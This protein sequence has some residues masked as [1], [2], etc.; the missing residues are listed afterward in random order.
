[1]SLAPATVQVLVRQEQF[2]KPLLLS[3]RR[4]GWLLREI[5]EWAESPQYHHA[6]G[7]CGDFPVSVRCDHRYRD[8]GRASVVQQRPARTMGA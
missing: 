1:M 8:S 2:P 3:G 5:E 7:E 6:C 4:V